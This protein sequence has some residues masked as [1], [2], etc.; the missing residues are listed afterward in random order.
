MAQ[1]GGACEGISW[2]HDAEDTLQSVMAGIYHHHQELEYVQC[3]FAPLPLQLWKQGSWT[4][5]QSDAWRHIVC[6]DGIVRCCLQ[7][8]ANLGLGF[9][10]LCSM[11]GLFSLCS[12]TF[13]SIPNHSCDQ[14]AWVRQLNGVWS[15]LEEEL[16]ALPKNARLHS[17]RAVLLCRGAFNSKLHM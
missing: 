4:G 8:L 10:S 6:H 5:Q 13:R 9:H 15:E 14:A 3:C 17:G 16:K 2:H 12:P 7:I 11:Q 1:D